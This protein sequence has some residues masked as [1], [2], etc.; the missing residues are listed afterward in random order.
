MST[1]IL[2]NLKADPTQ[3]IDLSA[4]EPD[5]LVGNALA[6]WQHFVVN[7]PYWWSESDLLTIERYCFLIGADRTLRREMNSADEAEDYTEYGK[8]WKTMKSLSLELK[9]VEYSLGVTPQGR[10]AL[11]LDYAEGQTGREDPGDT[12]DPIDPED[13]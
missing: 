2:K 4:H 11:K 13:L 7:T 9:N 3:K 8:L 10:A 5:G 1:P 6:V 12:D